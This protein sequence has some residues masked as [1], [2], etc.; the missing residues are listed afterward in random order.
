M[1]MHVNSGVL[2]PGRFALAEQVIGG[3]EPEVTYR[4]TWN[5]LPTPLKQLVE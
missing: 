5:A 4:E 1:P 3:P 2:P